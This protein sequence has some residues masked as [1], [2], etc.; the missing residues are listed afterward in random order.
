M[1]LIKYGPNIS[2]MSGAMGG[3]V[4]SRNRYG[5]YIRNRTKPVNPNSLRQSVVRNIMA[6]LAQLWNST[7]TA[8]ERNQWTEY[9]NNVPLVN[10]LGDTFFATGLN[11]YI[12]SNVPRIQAG[13]DRVDAGPVIFTLPGT[14][15]TVTIA[16]SEA[17][18]QIAVT[19][20]DTLDWA[21]EA[22][23]ALLVA[24]GQPVNQTINFFG[25]PWRF[26][27][28]IEGINPGGVASP[29]NVPAP[30]ILQQDQ[31]FFVQCRISLAD[32]RLS[33]FFR[34]SANCAA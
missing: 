7:L 27:D 34:T 5:A 26:G 30:F 1:A 18:Q 11:H 31:K 4:Y 29:Q 8:G 16:A 33:N 21:T 10:K 15:P 3:S 2:N 23:A 25:G 14:D 22:G 32:G 13:L 6:D 28:G 20:D 24:C 12:R 9:G 19:F 17:T